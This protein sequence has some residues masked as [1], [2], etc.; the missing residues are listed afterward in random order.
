MRY[1]FSIEIE[2]KTVEEAIKKGL[3]KIKLPR[4]EIK[5]EILKEEEAGLFKMPGAQRA[6]IRVIKIK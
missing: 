3:K 6:K 1:Q 5:I 4:E 2:A